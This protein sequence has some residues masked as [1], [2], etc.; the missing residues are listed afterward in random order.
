MISF[1]TIYL[2]FI[3]SILVG[4]TGGVLLTLGLIFKKNPIWISGI[5][6]LVVAL[7]TFIGTIFFGA[8]KL[9][10]FLEGKKHNALYS[11]VY[12]QNDT[13][14]TAKTDTTKIIEVSGSIYLKNN[15]PTY[16]KASSEKSIINKGIEIVSIEN[17]SASNKKTISLKMNFENDY[18]GTLIL[19]A[20]D[21]NKSS[22]ATAELKINIK[23]SKNYVI[24]FRFNQS[25]DITFIDHII[26]SEKAQL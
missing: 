1:F 26:L 10:K 7:F 20:Y 4:L 18:S 8:N 14:A 16:I 21:I 24:D 22:L 3:L 17:T 9:F 5:V 2:L 15:S 19:S 11:N 25:S 6:V 12:Y 13:T 23:K